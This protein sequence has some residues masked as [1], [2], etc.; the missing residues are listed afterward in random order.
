MSAV[1]TIFVNQEVSR[2]H[3]LLAAGDPAAA[4]AA[5]RD[6]IARVPQAALAY[7]LL[8]HILRLRGAAAE[9]AGALEAALSLDATIAQAHAEL[10]L[11]H[12]EA[13]DI[14]RAAPLTVRSLELSPRDPN[15]HWIAGQVAALAGRAEA[16]EKAFRSAETLAPG[17]G[18]H[19]YALGLA[20]LRVD[21]YAA[22]CIHLA[23]AVR[24][25]ATHVGAWANLGVALGAM[26]RMEES[27]RTLTRARDLAPGD[28]QIAAL[29]AQAV[30]TSN[31]DAD[32]K[33]AACRA[34]LALAPEDDEAGIRL[35]SALAQGYR[36]AEAKTIAHDIVTRNPQHLLALWLSF[37]LPLRMSFDTEEERA[38]HLAQWR[39][40]M[41][42]FLD[43]AQSRDA[44][45]PWAERVLDSISNYYLT[46]LPD[47]LV[48]EHR[49][50][51]RA[52]RLLVEALGLDAHERKA[53]PIARARR[54]VGIV[55][56]HL[57]AHSVSKVFQSTIA[58]LPRD[59]FELVAF[60]PSPRPDAV[61]R[62]WRE[63]VDAMIDGE[64]PLAE[65]V[66]RIAASDLDVLVYLDI[67]MHPVMNA[68]TALRLAPV[69]VALWGHPVT[70]GSDVV[71]WFVSADAME[72]PGADA[73]YTEQLVRLPRLGTAFAAPDVDATLPGER[74]I[75]ELAC[76]QNAAKLAPRGDA[77]W[78]RILA[79]CPNT[80]LSVYCGATPFV[81]DGLRGRLSRALTAAGVDP[82]RLAVFPLLRN[83]AFDAALRNVDVLLDSLDFSGGI[84]GFEC[85]ARELPIVS[86]PGPCM[87][88]RQTAAMLR[89]VGADEL[90]ARDEDDYV[91][92]ATRLAT[93][94]AARHASVARIAAGKASLFGD[95]DV[96][97]ALSQF[98]TQVQPRER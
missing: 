81:A 42:R 29:L 92:I 86:L 79:A 55:S 43:A 50:N 7:A 18:E 24:R 71:D 70:T 74:E 8:G 40:G 28:A 13:G 21:R 15:L 32:S 11:V 26:G 78:A 19:R 65:W 95:A 1:D 75:V 83:D 46:Y 16:A 4:E 25:S 85:L 39:D 77:L 38:Q 98:L 23:A 3:G 62:E 64:R 22:A 87:R 2:A 91:A 9:A 33:I 49:A 53:A 6:L 76:V 34:A 47:A 37:Q 57:H 60:Y 72:P 96:T 45:A 36:Y 20:A 48:D 90:V 59:A 35:V 14:A 97:A 10:G 67:G 80:R 31:A 61:T 44:A 56:P 73:H 66:S 89:Q 84:T 94:V 52:V 63:R 51:A 12:A 27:I 88:G 69:Q 5:C 68:L 58:G 30:L 54:R 82:A 41:A 17:I 93:D